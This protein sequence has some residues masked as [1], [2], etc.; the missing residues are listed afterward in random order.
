[1]LEGGGIF[2]LLNYTE[3]LQ[4]GSTVYRDPSRSVYPIPFITMEGAQGDELANL[5]TSTAHLKSG[6]VYMCLSA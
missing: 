4:H 2:T 5:G 6:E 3:V 1:M